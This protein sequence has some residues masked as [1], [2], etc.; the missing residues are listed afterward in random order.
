MIRHPENEKLS[1][2]VLGQL[3]HEHYDPQREQ[4]RKLEKELQHRLAKI[5]ELAKAMDVHSLRVLAIHKLLYG[6]QDEQ[7]G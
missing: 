3:M 7:A 4:K 6:D 2:S 1:L 5:R